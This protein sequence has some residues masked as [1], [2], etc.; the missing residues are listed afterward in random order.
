MSLVLTVD[1]SDA[2]EA[3]GDDEEFA[4]NTSIMNNLEH[5]ENEINKHLDKATKNIGN[6]G[7]ENISDAD[8]RMMNMINS[9]SKG[10]LINVS[11]MIGS[12]GQ[13]SVE[14]KRI[15]YGFDN[16]T[17]PHFTKYDDGPESRG[18]VE[19]SFIKGLTAQEFFFHAMGIAIVPFFQA[20]AIFPVVVN[21]I[22]FPPRC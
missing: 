18:F 22:D 12:V 6:I 3:S 9:K 1:E 11:Q 5:F 17:L 2:G 8:N 19:N 7:M 14:G 20:M 15:M 16:R 21:Q 4:M 10:N 13:Q